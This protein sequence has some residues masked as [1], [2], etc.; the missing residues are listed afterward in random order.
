VIVDDLAVARRVAGLQDG[1]GELGLGLGQVIPVG[2]QVLRRSNP[3]KDAVTR[4]RCP[5]RTKQ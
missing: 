5:Q 4:P 2:Y 3:P 1:G